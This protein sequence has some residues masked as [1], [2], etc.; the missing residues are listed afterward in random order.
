MPGRPR[1]R[2][3][4]ARAQSSRQP[5]LRCPHVLGSAGLSP[6]G[7]QGSAL[8]H[9]PKDFMPWNS[10]CK[11]SCFV[12]RVPCPAAVL[13]VDEGLLPARPPLSWC[14]LPGLLLAG[15]SG[16]PVPAGLSPDSPG[17]PDL[18]RQSQAGPGCAQRRLGRKLPVPT[19]SPTQQTA[20]ADRTESRVFGG[21]EMSSGCLGAA[22]GTGRDARFIR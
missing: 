4:G 13:W 18:P 5:H 12:P 1:Q 19:P 14:F 7:G 11:D 17:P 15:G 16:S 9:G 2:A 3:E 6:A 20:S 8:L 21:Q 10:P 22:W